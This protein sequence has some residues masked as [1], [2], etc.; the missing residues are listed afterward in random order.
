MSDTFSP[1]HPH[2]PYAAL[3]VPDFRLY[4]FARLLATIGFNYQITCISWQLYKITGDA[5]SLGLVGL[6][7]AIPFIMLSLFSGYIADLFD[8]K[9]IIILSMVGYCATVVGLYYFTQNINFFVQN[10]QAEYFIYGIV[11][12]TGI[13]RGF[14]APASYAFAA[15]LIKP[16]L[17]ANA[18]TWNSTAWHIGAISGPA[19]AGLMYAY[20]NAQNAYFANL[21]IFIGSL[22]LF[23]FIPP[24]P[25]PPV[26]KYTENETLMQKLTVGLKFVFGNQLF[27]GAITLDLFAVLFGGAVAV[28]P[29][30]ADKILLTDA[31]G[32]G[33]LRAAPAVGAVLMAIILA[34]F[35]I[36]QQLGKYLLVS[37]A[38]FGVCTIGFAYS[39]NFELSVILLAL[40]GAFDNVSVVVRGTLMQVLTPN[41]MRGR[42]ASVN[43]IFISSSNEIG[44]FE[45]GL[46]AHYLGLVPSVVFGGSM[47]VLV[48][49]LVAF[50][51]PLLRNLHVIKP[52]ED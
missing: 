41:H 4:I 33:I 1:T 38:M 11:F 34:Y 22:I 14:I 50:F 48:V 6:A 3:R 39:T 43:S 23:A 19:L 25:L 20:T 31:H 52:I 27:L 51:A 9:K 28:L 46:A 7:E 15:Q 42:V 44:A 29:V 47:T 37:V 5:F 17:Y 18:A 10:K 8:R 13:C 16:Q 30:F 2:D 21:F 40:I 24:K 36:K 35:P 45:S 49:V 12:I 32:L 26:S